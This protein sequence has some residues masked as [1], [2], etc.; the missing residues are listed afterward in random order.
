MPVVPQQLVE[1]L[2]AI[3]PQFADHWTSPDNLFR[4]DDGSFTFCGVFAAC[5]HLV[6]DHYQ[7]LSPEQRRSLAD[8][9]EECMTPPVTDLGTAAATCFLENLAYETFS[10]DLQGYLCGHALEFFRKMY[11]ALP[12]PQ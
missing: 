4:G 11:E 8:F 3:L 9:V 12:P 10:R 1:R 6:R 2:T 7:Q 5:S